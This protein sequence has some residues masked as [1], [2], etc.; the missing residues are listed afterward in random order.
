MAETEHR[1]VDTVARMAGQLVS[2]LEQSELS[3]W[4]RQIAAFVEDVRRDPAPAGDVAERIALLT[5]FTDLADAV[6]RLPAVCERPEACRDFRMSAFWRA[7]RTGNAPGD[8]LEGF[9]RE[10]DAWLNCGA[11]SARA[12]SWPVERARSLIRDRYADRLTM[13]S[14]GESVGWR[15]RVL[16]S[17]FRREVGVTLHDYLTQIR[18]RRAWELIRRGERIETVT[19]LVGY[20]SKKNFYRQFKRHVGFNPAACRGAVTSPALVRMSPAAP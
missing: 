11:R 10:F 3:Q 14:L 18:L 20:H 19:H 1:S 16:A 12:F 8:V 9:V 13:V 6:R 2:R 7:A 17:R 15:G 5:L 4:T